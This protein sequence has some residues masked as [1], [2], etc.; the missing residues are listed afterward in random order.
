MFHMIPPT[1]VDLTTE[2]RRFT[3]RRAPD[4]LRA[5]IGPGT[6]AADLET[7]ILIQVA[8]ALGL[9]PLDLDAEADLE[10]YGFRDTAA[11]V[12]TADLAGHL[13]REL[14]AHLFAQERTA[15]GVARY[16]VGEESDAVQ[17]IGF[18]FVRDELG[19]P[20]WTERVEVAVTGA[21]PSPPSGSAG[22]VHAESAPRTRAAC[23]P[24]RT[25]PRPPQPRFFS[26]GDRSAAR[27][28]GSSV[29]RTE[30][31]REVA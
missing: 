29:R 2:P 20:L 28:P 23:R 5:P 21:R 22:R 30:D 31:A 19:Y 26:A 13:E 8:Y 14:P 17:P 27:A 7:W 25:A 6:C 16:L 12:L 24:L 15:R 4:E 11:Q 3:W 18:R 1:R 9:D 10:G